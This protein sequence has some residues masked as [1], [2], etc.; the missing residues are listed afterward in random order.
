MADNIYSNLLSKI[1]NV[2]LGNLQLQIA[3]LF[4]QGC[5]KIKTGDVKINYQSEKK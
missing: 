4:Q 3:W 2:F 5:L 1:H